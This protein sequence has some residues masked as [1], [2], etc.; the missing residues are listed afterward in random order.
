MPLTVDAL[1]ER[2]ARVEREVAEMHRD[3]QAYAEMAGE[4]G[5]IARLSEASFA[6]DWDNELDAEYNRLGDQQHGKG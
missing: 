5:A 2:L 4:S 3:L 6:A 1:A